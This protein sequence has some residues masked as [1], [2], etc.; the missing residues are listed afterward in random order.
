MIVA[1]MST[2]KNRNGDVIETVVA[3][4]P[5]MLASDDVAAQLTERSVTL[6]KQRGHDVIMTATPRGTTGDEQASGDLAGHQ[7]ELEELQAEEQALDGEIRGLR[8][9]LRTL[10]TAHRMWKR[11]RRE[12]VLD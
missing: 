2:Y 4:P 12:A 10:A 3:H 8:E 5:V 9:R 11:Q 1:H 6:A 7:R